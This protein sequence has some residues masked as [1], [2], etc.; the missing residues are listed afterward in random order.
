ME[1]KLNPNETHFLFDS[2]YLPPL[3]NPQGRKAF[4]KNVS[5]EAA[6]LRWWHRFW[7]KETGFSDIF[8]GLCRVEFGWEY[9]IKRYKRKIEHQGFMDSI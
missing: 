3:R 4:R 2:A 8:I 1:T 5:R 6:R 7:Q 9:F